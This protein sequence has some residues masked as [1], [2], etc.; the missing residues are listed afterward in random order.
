MTSLLK[1]LMCSYSWAMMYKVFM[2]RE[3]KKL[4]AGDLLYS[5]VYICIYVTLFLSSDFRRCHY[6][7]LI[8]LL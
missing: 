8:L 4:V 6:F 1:L 7:N 3:K 2:L 5:S